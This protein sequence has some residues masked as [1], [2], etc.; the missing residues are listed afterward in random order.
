MI[1]ISL[2]EVI[3]IIL[4]IPFKIQNPKTNNSLNLRKQY[5]KKKESRITKY[6]NYKNFCNDS[7]RTELLNELNKRLIRISDLDHFNTLS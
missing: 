7:F 5:I 3:L 1:K 6:R 2:I 4:I